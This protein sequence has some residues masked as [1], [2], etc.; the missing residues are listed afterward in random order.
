MNPPN[1]TTIFIVDDHPFVCQGIRKLLE[2][3]PSTLIVGEAA[4]EAEAE[5]EIRQLTPDIVLCDISLR[6]GSGINLIHTLHR[7]LPDV[8]IIV[9]TMHTDIGY[10]I[11]L[12]QN[13][14][15]GYLFK[16]DSP[17]E[18][19]KTISEVEQGRTYF[20]AGIRSKLGEFSMPAPSHRLDSK[21]A[22]LNPQEIRVLT[23]LAIGFH[24]KQIA[25]LINRSPRTIEDYKGSMSK[26]LGIHS[27]SELMIFALKA[28]LVRTEDL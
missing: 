27:I 10:F 24:L 11:A 12:F 17:D 23:L 19:T 14:I 26:K 16:S 18:F 2:T 25:E 5:R 8:K 13:G 15:S 1:P 21:L 28:G 3:I 20:G 6:E 4:T 22:S 7:D 9:I